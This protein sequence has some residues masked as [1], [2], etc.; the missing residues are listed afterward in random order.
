MNNAMVFA[1]LFSIG[2]IGQSGP[3]GEKGD[4]GERGLNGASGP[5]GAD[6]KDG[7]STHTPAP[8]WVDSRGETVAAWV[9]E[10]IYLDQSGNQWT[11]IPDEGRVT[12]TV[13]VDFTFSEFAD[14][15]GQQW[16]KS[17]GAG[18]VVKWMSGDFLRV[19]SKTIKPV[20]IVPYSRRSIVTGSCYVIDEQVEQVMVIAESF[21]EMVWPRLEWSPPLHLELR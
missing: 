19:Q 18:V 15:S 11:L 6:G 5:R 4:V 12:V 3:S 2:C 17:S 21:T 7:V 8:V 9:G 20:K 14:C 1:L 10:R 13:S 16:A